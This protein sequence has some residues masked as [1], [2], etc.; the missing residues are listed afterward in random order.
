MN[1]S[2]YRDKWDS[3]AVSAGKDDLK[4][5]SRQIAHSF[6]DYYLKDCRYEAEY[7]DL[8]CEMTT[9]SNDPEL[10]NPG[11]HALFSIIV[12]RLCDDFEALQPNMVRQKGLPAR[13]ARKRR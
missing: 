5:L 2:F 11:A 12:E 1:S 10:N 8:L 6:L 3:I 13:F 9:F 4:R 7:I